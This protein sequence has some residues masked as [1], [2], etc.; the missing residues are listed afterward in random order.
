[1]LIRGD[2][3]GARTRSRAEERAAVGCFLADPRRELEATAPRRGRLGGRGAAARV[4]TAAHEQRETAEAGYRRA[5]RCDLEQASASAGWSQAGGCA[6][7]CGVH[8]SI[9]ARAPESRL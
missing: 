2:R 6:G 7:G 4:G 8:A 3:A 5:R 1:M 9:E